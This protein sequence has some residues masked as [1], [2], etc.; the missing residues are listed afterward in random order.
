MR[1]V[2]WLVLLV[3][4]GCAHQPRPPA[5]ASELIWVA[6][7]NAGG[8]S[9]QA[10]SGY[11]VPNTVAILRRSGVAVYASVREGLALPDACD[12]PAYAAIH[13]ALI[14]ERNV[15]RAARAG[16]ERRLPSQYLL[17]DSLKS[18][19]SQPPK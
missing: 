16:Y 7:A 14:V 6:K 4:M 13:Y 15:D 1:R 18:Q 11:E 2:V 3:G 8:V 12:S 5:E 19:P 9:C 17:P 10:D